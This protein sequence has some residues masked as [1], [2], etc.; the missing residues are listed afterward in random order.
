MC[1]THLGDPV[2]DPE[3]HNTEWTHEFTRFQMNTILNGLNLEWTH[4][5]C[6]QSRMD[7]NPNG[8][9]PKWTRFRT[10]TIPNVYLH[11]YTAV[12]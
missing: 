1:R 3:K 10:N 6:T 9:H 5:E 2:Y 12:I 4:L 11:L 7:I 8:D